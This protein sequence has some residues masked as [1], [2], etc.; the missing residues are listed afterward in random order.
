MR[1]EGDENLVPD[2]SNVNDDAGQPGINKF[3]SN[4]CDHRIPFCQADS[5][6]PADSAMHVRGLAVRR[7]SLLRRDASAQAILLPG[8]KRARSSSTLDAIHIKAIDISSGKVNAFLGW[9]GRRAARCLVPLRE[10]VSEVRPSRP[11]VRLR[12]SGTNGDTE[13]P[14]FLS[15]RDAQDLTPGLAN[16]NKARTTRMQ[17]DPRPTRGLHSRRQGGNIGH[18]SSIV[19]LSWSFGVWE[20]AQ[21]F[22]D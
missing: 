5:S 19:E 7:G 16:R 17:P 1:G 21:A 14:G 13:I 10:T 6:P 12:S 8:G 18:K 22:D 11:G 2:A 4:A 9:H 15:V 20:R 3:S